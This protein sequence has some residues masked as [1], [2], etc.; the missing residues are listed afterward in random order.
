MGSTS[1]YSGRF[2][3]V[4]ADF[5]L[6]INWKYCSIMHRLHATVDFNDL[7]LKPEVT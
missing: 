6:M 3:K 4:I 7:F 5:L 2:W 1:K